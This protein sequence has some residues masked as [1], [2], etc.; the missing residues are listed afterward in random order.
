MLRSQDI[1]LLDKLPKTYVTRIRSSPLH[2]YPLLGIL[3]LHLATMR[4]V[5]WDDSQKKQDAIAI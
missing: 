3:R 5:Y 2:Y 1:A 4:Q